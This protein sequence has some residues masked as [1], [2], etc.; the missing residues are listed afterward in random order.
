MKPTTMALPNHQLPPSYFRRLSEHV[1]LIVLNPN[2]FIASLFFNARGGGVGKASDASPTL[3]CQISR[4]ALASSFL[5]ILCARSTIE[6][7]TNTRENKGLNSPGNV[8]PL[9]KLNCIPIVSL[10]HFIYSYIYISISLYTW[11]THSGVIAS[12]LT[13]YYGTLTKY[14]Y[15]K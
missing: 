11:V 15:A 13:L 9:P 4:L 5:V 7:K 8:H 2:L 12:C 14:Q 6:P 10:A 1:R 3:P